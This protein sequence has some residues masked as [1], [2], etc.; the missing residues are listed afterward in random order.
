MWPGSERSLN[1]NV[2]CD[3][4]YG[5]VID[6]ALLD[7]VHAEIA[8]RSNW[9]LTLPPQPGNLSSWM[10]NLAKVSFLPSIQRSSY[11]VFWSGE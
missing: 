7:L 8:R 10:K 2:R 6:P 11:R 1:V 5:E 4:G 3:Q 9:S